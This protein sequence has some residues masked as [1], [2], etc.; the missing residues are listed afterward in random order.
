MRRIVIA[1][2]VVASV[3][4]IYLVYSN[5]SFPPPIAAGSPTNLIWPSESFAPPRVMVQNLNVVPDAATAPD[6]KKTATL[7][8]ETKDKGFHRILLGADGIEKGRDYT[9][10]L[11]V[12]EAEQNKSTLT[13]RDVMLE[14]GDGLSGPDGHYGNVHFDLGK[15]VVLSAS[16]GLKN[17][18]A[19]PE[20]GGWARVW[21]TITVGSDR[22]SIAADLVNPDVG[23][24]YAGDGNSGLLIWGMQLQPGDNLGPYIATTTGP[25]RTP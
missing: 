17:S 14:F 18:G 3:A 16:D 9:L 15:D 10:S 19:R 6:G 1:G 11:Y 21:A 20:D 25:A 23:A 8:I 2:A 13:A 7:L 12:K 22:A 4:I 5:R 24:V